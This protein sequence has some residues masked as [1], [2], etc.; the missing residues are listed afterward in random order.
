[1]RSDKQERIRS[2]QGEDTIR[3][4]NYTQEGGELGVIRNFSYFQKSFQEHF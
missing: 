4:G 2:P 3:Q 1:M